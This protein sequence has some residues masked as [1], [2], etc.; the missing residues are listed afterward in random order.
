[1]PTESR[2]RA[3]QSPD[4]YYR[5]KEAAIYDIENMWKT[6][7]IEFWKSMAREYAGAEGAALELA[8]GTLR[9]LL[10]VAESGITVTGIDISLYMLAVAKKKLA[11]AAPDVQARVTLREGDM[12]TLQLNRKFNLIYLPFNTFLVM[13]TAKDQ[14]A[15]FDAVR[16]HLAPGGVFAFDVFVPD[17]NRLKIEHN[18]AW[19]LE[20]DQPFPDVGIRFQRDHVREIDPIRQTLLV[21]YRMREYKDDVLIREWLS[22]LKITYIFPREVEHLIARAG[23]EIVHFWGEYDRRDFYAMH[24]PQKQLLVVPPK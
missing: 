23:F 16:A 17:I 20:I 6:D 2:K 22:D 3:V 12:R 21:H 24:N 9:V 11:R 19:L 4:I 7:D 5:E 18:P 14:L 10:P 1:M 15:M 13:L 8:C